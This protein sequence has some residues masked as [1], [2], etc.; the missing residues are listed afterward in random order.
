MTLTLGLGAALSGL[1]TA[2][3][4]LDLT[5]HNIANVNTEGFTRKDFNPVS[6]VLN[7]HGVGVEVMNATREVDEGL[8]RDIRREGGILKKL[9]VL[10]TYYDR[11]QDLFGTPEA[12]AS[13]SH[14]INGV[15]QE[16][17]VLAVSPSNAIAQTSAV[18]T[19]VGLTQKMNTL[20][21]SVQEL[22]KQ[23]DEALTAAVDT[24]NGLLEN[25]ASL[26]DKI[27]RDLATQR[28]ASDL[29]D[30]RDLAL[31]KLSELMDVQTFI[32]E[33]G[34]VVVFT[35]SGTT[36]VDS[37]EVSLS[38]TAVTAI[39]PWQTK[40]GEDFDGIEIGVIDITSEMR[41]GR[42]KGLVD[43][44]DSVLPD[45][46]AELDQLAS[47]LQ[48]EVN[49]IH[50]RGVG[51]PTLPTE[52]TGTRTFV[53]SNTQ[54]IFLDGTVRLVL[55]DSSGAEVA[56][57][58]LSNLM[59]GSSGGTIN[60]VVAA[61]DGFLNT[62]LGA[63]TYAQ[64]DDGKLSI[65][66]PASSGV[67][68]VFRDEVST[69][70]RTAKDATVSFSTDGIGDSSMAEETVSGFLNFFGLNDLL[71][72]NRRNWVWESSLLA[73]KATV[74]ASGTLQLGDETN[75]IITVP[76][77]AVTASDT[78]KTLA[79]KINDD[80]TLNQ[81]FEAEVVPEGGGERLRI[82]HRN[83]EEMVVTKQIGTSVLAALGLA[84]GTVGLSTVLTVRS[85]IVDT[86]QKI[87]RSFPQFSVDLDAYSVSTG[88]NTVANQL[89]NLSDHL[90]V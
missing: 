17:E 19:M 6:R 23:A 41:Q 62:Q 84:K 68:L 55:I 28:G 63:G 7:A 42:I 79:A 53:D 81:S 38:H 36:L 47:T 40:A 14:A 12:N 88:D 46:Q 5:A 37:S 24:A 78:L 69:T 21:K 59:G 22:R 52:M 71:V 9:D 73:P 87:S 77:L 57:D 33:S 76:T 89:A 74:G 1:M 50:N 39:A 3:K 75:G 80:T 27:V 61:I 43:L 85:D 44:R 72:S 83:G 35:T 26:N 15:A 65:T 86:P 90:S 13:L 31:R 16:L 8:L 49:T 54:K 2:R 64:I 82:K 20:S 67:G 34:A 51:F 30:Q 48:R 10:D 66:I 29:M 56:T 60:E 4:G 11:M 45:L 32:R 25:I 70:D 18:D 58:T